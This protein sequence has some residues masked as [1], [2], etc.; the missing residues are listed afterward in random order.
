MFKL[1]LSCCMSIGL[2]LPTA[3]A[4]E[5]TQWFAGVALGG[6]EL[7]TGVAAK[8]TFNTYLVGGL[9][10]NPYF[11]AEARAGLSSGVDQ[12]NFGA[13]LASPRA[14]WLVSLLAKPMYPVND[15]FSVYG[16]LG[17]TALKAS[18]SN[19]LAIKY[20]KSSVDISYGAGAEFKFN[21]NIHF[22]L[23]WVRYSSRK[24]QAT[25]NTPNFKGL[26]VSAVNGRINYY[27]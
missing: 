22:A 5:A 2:C 13:Q 27:F 24:D 21:Q 11:A 6:M 17:V 20:T 23:E 3:F 19:T 1:L 26:D 4:N 14:E 8:S 9:Q 7:D 15:L 12:P 18:Y 16:L 10:L 25:L